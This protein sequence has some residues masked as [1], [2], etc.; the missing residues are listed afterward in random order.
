[1]RKT[2]IMPV[3]S[4]S[5]LNFASQTLLRITCTQIML[6]LESCQD[7]NKP[8]SGKRRASSYLFEFMGILFHAALLRGSAL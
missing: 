4:V 3:N 7:Q 6:N 1:M 2:E 8:A 5:S